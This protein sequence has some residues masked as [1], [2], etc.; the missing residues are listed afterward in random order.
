MSFATLNGENV[1]GFA[2]QMRMVQRPTVEQISEFFGVDNVFSLYGGKR[3]RIFM[4]R[5]ILAG[6]NMSELNAAEAIFDTSQAGNIADGTSRTLVTPRGVV[7]QN[8]I[9]RGEYE[10]ADHGPVL[11]YF[12]GG[13]GFILPYSLILH[14]LS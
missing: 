7:Y 4:T 2:V 12:P 11:G 8:V 1:F 9:Y 13:S 5:G 6:G 14:G 10:P 3:G